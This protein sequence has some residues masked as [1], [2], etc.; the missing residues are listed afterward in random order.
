[1]SKRF[2]LSLAALLLLSGLCGALDY[3]GE[4]LVEGW[5]AISESQLTALETTFA[6]LEKQTEELQMRLKTLMEKSSESQELL[7]TSTQALNAASVSLNLL[8][9]K[10]TT[11]TAQRNIAVIC[12]VVLPIATAV[13]FLIF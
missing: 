5:Y 9:T 1:M 11:L 10:V 12:A 2:S 8:D 4:P 13:L 3:P 6:E 7:T